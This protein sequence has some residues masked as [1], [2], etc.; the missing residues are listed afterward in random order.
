M[1]AVRIIRRL[2][3]ERAR[4]F[5]PDVELRRQHCRPVE[6]LG[7]GGERQRAVGADDAEGAVLE[8]DVA[9]GG[10]QHHRRHRLGLFDDAVGGA[11]ERIAA[12]LHAARAIGAAAE[13]YGI[14]VA[15]HEADVLERHAEPFR[16]HLRID[17]LVALAVRMR[18][19]ENGQHA[20]RIEAD[21]HAV[22][23]HRGFLEEIADA[24]AAQLAVPLGFGGA[25]GETV[26]IGELEALVHH[27]REIAAVIGD[28]GLDL[29]RH[30]GRPE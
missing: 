17:G 26:P 23:E 2:G 6:A 13:R 3:G 29:V 24:A 25:F 8:F 28:A 4:R 9:G 20:A 22:V 1:A 16:H 27:M 15:L 18:A 10:F 5:E 14:G 11:L 21:D 19:G 12:D 30:G 7:D